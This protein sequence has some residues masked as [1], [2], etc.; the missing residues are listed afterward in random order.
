MHECYS[1]AHLPASAPACVFAIGQVPLSAGAANLCTKINQTAYPKH[2]KT[3]EKRLDFQGRNPAW[4]SMPENACRCNSV[5]VLYIVCKYSAVAGPRTCGGICLSK[6]CRF[7]KP[8]GAVFVN[9]R[10]FFCD[11]VAHHFPPGAPSQMLARA[12]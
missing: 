2:R 7:C 8:L 1:R 11:R 12:H 4:I 10:T 3:N 9:R 5:Y 6:P